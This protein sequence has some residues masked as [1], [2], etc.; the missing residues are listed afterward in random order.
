MAIT[1]ELFTFSKRENSTR[2]PTAETENYTLTYCNLKHNCGVVSPAL[3]FQLD[4]DPAKYNYVRIP[5]WGRYYWITAW[6]WEPN[7][8]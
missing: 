1:V 4:G 3:L 6:T 8:L 2:R 7:A 5:G